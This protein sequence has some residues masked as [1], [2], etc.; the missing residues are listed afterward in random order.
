VLVF[1]AGRALF[2]SAWTGAAA[3]LAQLAQIGL[4][5]GHG[6]GYTTLAHP[7]A[8]T[9]HLIVPALLALSF[10]YVRDR[11]SR[12]LP[13]IAAGGLVL[14]LVHPTY[15]LFFSLVFAGFLLAR[16]LL[17]GVDIGATAAALG[18]VVVPAGVVAFWLLPIVRE[19]ASHEPSRSQLSSLLTHYG[20]QLDVSSVD[21]FRLAPEA[22][23]RS[24]AVAVAAL[25]LVPLA[26]LAPRRR[27]AA[28]VLGSALTVLVVTLVPEL[29]T[30]LSDV[31]SLSQ[32]RRLAGFVPFAFAF[33]GGLAVLARLLGAFVL[34][35]AL[36]AGVVL[37]WAFPGDFGYRLDHGGPA[38]ATWIAA[39]GGAAAL[40]LAMPFLRRLNVERHGA[41]VTLAAALFVLPIAVDGLADW[42]PREVGSG[43]LTPGL[44]HALRTDVPEADVVYS[45]MATSYHLAAYA[46]VYIAAAPPAHVAD[47]TAN[48]PYERRE[49]VKEF[50]KTGDLA[51]PRRY[52]AHWLV[53]DEL[54][55]DL[56]PNLPR[57]YHDGRYALYRIPSAAAA[58]RLQVTPG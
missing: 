22:V 7:G 58:G 41:L 43:R 55:R 20:G 44:I 56:R 3:V 6:G 25:L 57:V 35:F 11:D 37:Q 47:T 16:G 30:R 36:A 46:P 1:A 10:A 54:K 19:T 12:L 17:A 50:F 34:P 28:F 15:A 38:A 39:Y 40:A 18:A 21:S 33:A 42:G 23:G 14:A 49:D 13:A 53:I 29:F 31:V 4:A 48:R 32:A 2:R 27:W 9:R 52:G 5:P 45:D 26:A 24:G 51:I 8:A